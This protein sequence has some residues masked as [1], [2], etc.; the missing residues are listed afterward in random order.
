MPDYEPKPINAI[1]MQIVGPA[2]IILMVVSLVFFLVEVTYRGP[3]TYRLYWVMALFTFASVLVS[4]ISIQEGKERAALFGFALAA[5]TFVTC[6]TIVEFKYPGFNFLG[7]IVNLTLIAVVMWSVSKLTWDCTVLDRSR[8]S[9]ATGL[10][11][12]MRERFSPEPD[13]SSRSENRNNESSFARFINWMSGKRQ[14]NTPGIWVFYFGIFAFPIFGLGQWFVQPASKVW[15]YVLFAMYLG[16]TLCLLM[17]TSLLGLERYLAKRKL[18]VPGAVAQNWL[19]VGTVFALSMV[20]AVLILPKP[21]GSQSLEW[22]AQ[23]S[24]PVQEG[25]S[26]LAPGNDGQQEDPKAQKQRVDENAEKQGDKPGNKKAKGSGKDE[27]EDK[28]GKGSSSKKSEQENNHRGEKNPGEKSG[29]DEEQKNQPQRSKDKNDDDKNS[30]D[31]Q[32]NRPANRERAKP[33]QPDEKPADQNDDNPRN[34]KRGDKKA[35]LKN[36][37]E[38]GKK[39]NSANSQMRNWLDGI[40]KFFNWLV[41][42]V[43]FIAIIFVLWIFRGE[44]AKILAAL[45]GSEQKAAAASGTPSQPEYVPPLPSFRQFQDPFRSGKANSLRAKQVLDYTMSALQAWAREFD[46]ETSEDLTP[47]ELAREIASVNPVVSRYA[48]EF[49]SVYGRCAFAQ[50]TIHREELNPLIKLWRQMDLSFAQ[51]QRSAKLTPQQA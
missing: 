48:L 25:D 4:R 18:H 28:N 24:S 36:K 7:P 47:E 23:W 8:D 41:Y 17:T 45:F 22:L 11:D 26:K 44:I 9:S 32:K 19:V 46:F 50:D 51:R 38:A 15:V 14:K 34:Q 27:S 40:S 33:I 43:G 13:E 42:L 39:P 6:S 31:D 2:L 35:D 3:H 21:G 37:K 30:N 20:L 1:L 29:T 10:V 49:A 16:S 12:L 5:A